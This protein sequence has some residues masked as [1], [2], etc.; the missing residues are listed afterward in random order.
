MSKERIIINDYSIVQANNDKTRF[1]SIVNN[2][3]L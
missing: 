1:C 2:I 3:N